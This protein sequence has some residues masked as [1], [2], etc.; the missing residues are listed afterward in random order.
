MVRAKKIK[1]VE[2]DHVDPVGLLSPK[3]E[4]PFPDDDIKEICSFERYNSGGEKGEWISVN[5]D[6]G[7]AVT[8]IPKSLSSYVEFK[9][10]AHQNNTTR[11]P[12]ENFYQMK[13]V[14]F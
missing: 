9:S 3:S 5:F 6:T 12:V 11:L 8:A 10:E 4:W 7:A 2:R 13:A 1:L 14:C